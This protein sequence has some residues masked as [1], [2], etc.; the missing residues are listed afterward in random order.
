MA[1]FSTAAFFTLLNHETSSYED[2]VGGVPADVIIFYRQGDK[3]PTP[4]GDAA[5]APSSVDDAFPPLSGNTPDYICHGHGS[6][7]D[8]HKNGAGFGGDSD[9]GS[10]GT[11]EEA[12]A[13]AG[14]VGDGEGVLTVVVRPLPTTAPA[15]LASDSSKAE[16]DIFQSEDSFFMV[17]LISC[18]V[19]I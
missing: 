1:V 8:G 3:S 11:R 16:G 4:P 6:K 17:C 12:S 2:L 19:L 7:A 18:L 9:A 10:Q 14:A 13:A 5:L 15:S